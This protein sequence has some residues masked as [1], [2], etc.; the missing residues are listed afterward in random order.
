MPTGAARIVAG[1][2]EINYT[3]GDPTLKPFWRAPGFNHFGD[4]ADGPLLIE[5]LDR[6]ADLARRVLNGWRWQLY[7]GGGPESDKVL[8]LRLQPIRRFHRATGYVAGRLCRRD[9]RRR[10]SHSRKRS[11]R[12]I[13]STPA[14]A[15]GW[16]VRRFRNGSASSCAAHRCDKPAPRPIALTRRR[17]IAPLPGSVERRGRLIGRL[18]IFDR[19]LG[20]RAQVDVRPY[21]A[22]RIDCVDDF[23]IPFA[24]RVG[25]VEF[26]L[27]RSPVAQRRLC[28]RTSSCQS[29]ALLGET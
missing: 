1:V 13:P 15:A 22:R 17:G 4:E 16:P 24:C 23:Q 10:R 14:P 18:V 12:H 7:S 29:P 21:R 11:S 20:D 28:P 26:D 27:E 6:I 2:R 25:A 8:R 19:D 5:S 3:A 9:S